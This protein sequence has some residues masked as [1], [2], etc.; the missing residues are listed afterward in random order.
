MGI[1]EAVVD[2]PPVASGP[3]NISC[4]EQPH[5]LAHDILRDA[6][7]LRKVAHAQLAGLEQRVKNR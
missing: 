5:A 4:A 3:H 6:G 2:P 1:R 7:D